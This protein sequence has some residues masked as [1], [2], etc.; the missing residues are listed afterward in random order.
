[1]IEVVWEMIVKPEAQGRLEL[2]Y[3]PG[4]VWSKLVG[5]APGFRGTTVLNDTDNPTRYL[6]V[7]LWDSA[8]QQAQALESC[9]EDY[10]ALTADLDGWTASRTPLGV[11]RV[12]AEATVRPRGKSGRRS[13]R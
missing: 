6:I 7:N 9:A 10:A 13:R 3:G 4:G 1:M 2:V 8:E 11:F 5:S 12:R